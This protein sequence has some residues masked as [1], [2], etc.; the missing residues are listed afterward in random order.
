MVTNADFAHFYTCIRTYNY[1]FP[2]FLNPLCNNLVG[3]KGYIQLYSLFIIGI[4]KS[5]I[6]GRT[7][8]FCKNKIHSQMFELTFYS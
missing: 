7:I 8:T 1:I 6:F 3:I 2:D 5:T 4:E